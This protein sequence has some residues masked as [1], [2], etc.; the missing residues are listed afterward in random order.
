MRCRRAQAEE[1][2]T[3]TVFR[4]ARLYLRAIDLMGSGKINIEPLLTNGYAFACNVEVV[5]DVRIARPASV[6]IQSR[7]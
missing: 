2:R 4:F 6:K 5:E 1:A 3:E 7:G